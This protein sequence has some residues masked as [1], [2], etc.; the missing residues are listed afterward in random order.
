MLINC[1][2]KKS[3]FYCIFHQLIVVGVFSLELQKMFIATSWSLKFSKG[4]HSFTEL[5]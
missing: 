5:K 4:K 1:T 3:S 2:V